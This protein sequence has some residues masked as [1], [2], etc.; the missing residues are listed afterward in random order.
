MTY[1]Q[2]E[3]IRSRK[4]EKVA[5]FLTAE[6]M[7]GLLIA[8]LPVYIA[9]AQFQ[10]FALRSVL[11]IMAAVFGVAVTLEVAGLPMYERVLWRVRG[12]MRVRMSGAV[13]TP[14]QFSPTPV[15]APVQILPVDGPIRIVPAAHA[16][17]FGGR[18][19]NLPCGGALN[20]M[21]QAPRTSPF[22]EILLRQAERD[23][24]PALA[25]VA[26]PQRDAPK[27]VAYVHV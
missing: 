8:T 22:D 23:A 1:Q 27:E 3:E 20:S 24:G 14:D 2:L 9:T 17:P 7:G 5:L 6:N 13:L 18:R 11:L 10:S 19:L 15:A 12:L 25:T 16:T 26:I 4:R 21:P